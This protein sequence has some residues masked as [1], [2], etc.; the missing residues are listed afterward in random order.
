MSKKNN[1]AIVQAE[2]LRP[3]QSAPIDARKMIEEIV[4]QK[5]AEIMA[6]PD[7]LLEPFMQSKKVQIE[8]TKLQD[9]VQQKKFR[10]YF[11]DWGCLICGQKDA[12]YKSVGMCSPCFSRVTNRMAVSLRNAYA[13][14][15]VFDKPKDLVAMAQEALAPSI[16]ALIPANDPPALKVLPATTTA[17]TKKTRRP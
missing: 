6:A 4:K 11:E 15:P 12:G 16:K 10:F 13:E 1:Q 7:S 3:A 8:I 2:V 9:V 5:V 17:K 14:R